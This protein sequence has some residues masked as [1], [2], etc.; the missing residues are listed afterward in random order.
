MP[1]TEDRMRDSKGNVWVTDT[2]GCGR[3]NIRT[4]GRRAPPP[5]ETPSPPP[6]L[7]PLRR[8]GQGI[9]QRPAELQHKVR[10]NDG[11]APG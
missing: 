2:V 1:Q 5:P 7:F 8:P 10:D 11:A 6:L 9:C 3:G 4:E